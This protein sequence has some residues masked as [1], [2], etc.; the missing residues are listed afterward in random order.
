MNVDDLLNRLNS[1]FDQIL[2]L[3]SNSTQLF[4]LQSLYDTQVPVLVAP[5]DAHLER[6]LR[7]VRGNLHL[8]G[9][10]G[11]R[12]DHSLPPVMPP[13]RDD[14]QLHHVLRALL[15]PLRLR[16]PP[17]HSDTAVVGDDR[18]LPIRAPHRLSGPLVLGHRN[19]LLGH[20]W[21]GPADCG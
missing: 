19:G 16:V 4:L 5:T 9:L 15:R 12:K 13:Q 6:H 1:T 17:L 11:V 3:P 21:L 7:A 14:A 10:L 2:V 18:G 20:R 8:L